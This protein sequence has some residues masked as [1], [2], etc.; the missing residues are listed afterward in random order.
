MKFPSES[1]RRTHCSNKSVIASTLGGPWPRPGLA[2]SEPVCINATN[3]DDALCRR[4]SICERLGRNGARGLRRPP[5]RRAVQ[6][7]RHRCQR[8]GAFQ[9]SCAGR[10]G[11]S[12][13]RANFNP[14]LRACRMTSL[15]AC[16]A[17]LAPL[18]GKLRLCLRGALAVCIR[19]RLAGRFAATVSLRRLLQGGGMVALAVAFRSGFV[20]LGRNFVMLGGLGVTCHWHEDSPCQGLNASPRRGGQ[21][22]HHAGRRGGAAAS[23]YT[24]TGLVLSHG[25]DPSPFR[26]SPT[27]NASGR[28]GYFPR[29]AVEQCVSLIGGRLRDRRIRLHIE[30]RV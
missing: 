28:Y 1:I 23:E 14:A 3:D 7:S 17:R 29:L 26:H 22:E 13:E 6:R 18:R 4:A 10:A 15:L 8:S 30:Q 25:A 20:R 9:S 5:P 12:Q 19:G 27:G 2:W 16:A 24:Q 11:H 21:L